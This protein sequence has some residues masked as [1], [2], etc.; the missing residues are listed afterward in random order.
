[1]GVAFSQFEKQNTELKPEL[2]ADLNTSDQNKVEKASE[3]EIM[4]IYIQ[5]NNELNNLRQE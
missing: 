5:D 1:L 4:S 2:H 3:R